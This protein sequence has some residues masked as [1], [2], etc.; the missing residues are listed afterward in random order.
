[1]FVYLCVCVG[2]VWVQGGCGPDNAVFSPGARAHTKHNFE[3]NI[4]P[5][6]VTHVAYF[7]YTRAN[8]PTSMNTQNT[9]EQTDRQTD[10]QTDKQTDRQTDKQ[11]NRQTDKRGRKHNLLGGGNN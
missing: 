8:P 3:N 11:T 6:V 10:R 7:A 1:M 2:S 4:F 5:D 9:N